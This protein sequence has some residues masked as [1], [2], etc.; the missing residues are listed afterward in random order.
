MA[1][2][3]GSTGANGIPSVERPQTLEGSGAANFLPRSCWP[4]RG[5]SLHGFRQLALVQPGKAESRKRLGLAVERV[6]PAG[7]P[8]DAALDAAARPRL[9]VDGHAQTDPQRHAAGRERELDAVAKRRAAGC[10]PE[11]RAGWRRRAG[12]ARRAAAARR[13]R[14]TS[15]IGRLGRQV[16]LDV[17][18][19]AD[20]GDAPQH[21][22]RRDDVADAEAGR[23]DLRERADV[24]DE[25]RRGPRWRAAARAGRRSGTR[26][27]SRP[28]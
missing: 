13:P 7:V 14:S 9:D 17:E 4:C 24:D 21:R 8:G 19:R 16:S 11:S 27:R 20:R 1:E 10:W 3:M 22:R 23:E 25:R 18:Q 12:R 28:R 15:A 26:G 5:H 2:C 6:A